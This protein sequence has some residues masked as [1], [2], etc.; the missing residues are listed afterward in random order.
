MPTWPAFMPEPLRESIT[1]SGPKGAVLRTQMD[2]G[3]AKQR[4]RFTAAPKSLSLAYEPLNE[5]DVILF[6][7]FFEVNLQQGALE[8]DMPHPISEIVSKFRFADPDEPYR[9]SQIG[10][11]AYRLTVSIELLP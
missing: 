2:A 9:L 7:D 11:N 1:L 4:Q 10:K 3:P 8:F 6:E 5:N